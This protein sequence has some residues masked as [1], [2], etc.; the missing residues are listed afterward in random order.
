MERGWITV[1]NLILK[2]IIVNTTSRTV[3]LGDRS[4]G[5]REGDRVIENDQENSGEAKEIDAG[6]VRRNS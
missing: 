1:V 6:R 2:N 5:N 3:K 4:L